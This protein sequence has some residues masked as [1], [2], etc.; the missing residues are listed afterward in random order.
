MSSDRART[1]TPPPRGSGMVAQLKYGSD[2]SKVDANS[3][4][5]SATMIKP[6]MVLGGTMRTIVIVFKVNGSDALL[7]DCPSATLT[8]NELS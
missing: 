1:N 5:I 8:L 3:R 4:F 6:S 7:I 2:S